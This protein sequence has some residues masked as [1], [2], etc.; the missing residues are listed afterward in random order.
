MTAELFV[1]QE[2]HVTAVL[3]EMEAV[4][5]YDGGACAPMDAIG[6]LLDGFRA[7]F[8]SYRPTADPDVLML[9]LGHAAWQAFLKFN[10]DDDVTR[11]LPP[12]L[13]SKHRRY[14]AE[15]LLRWG[16]PG[17]L[18]RIDSKFRRVI[19]MERD[20]L[21][22]G[23]RGESISDTLFDIVGYCVLGYYLC[24]KEEKA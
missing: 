4:N 3:K 15:P 8:Q 7:D 12:V 19:N 11:S 10:P 9:E 1:T 2:Q 24:K 22:G 18:I 5:E 6:I 21:S 20:E 14:G 16:V 23:E 13:I 17:V